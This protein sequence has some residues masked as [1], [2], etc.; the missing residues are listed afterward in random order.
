M[1]ATPPRTET[2][3][4]A[5]AR[6]RRQVAALATALGLASIVVSLVV[7]ALGLR[8]H[9]AEIDRSGQV[10]LALQL[11]AFK[12]VFD[13]YRPL[14]A[15]FSEH[16]TM[17]AFLREPDQPGNRAEL[18][19][20]LERL[21]G[22]TA[23]LDV[24]LVDQEHRLFSSRD[25]LTAAEI[26]QPDLQN[27]P[28]QGRLGRAYLARP[29]GL[30]PLAQ[31]PVYLFSHGIRDH[32]RY[33]GALVV[34]LG[35]SQLEQIWA[36]APYPVRTIDQEGARTLGNTL[37]LAHEAGLTSMRAYSSALPQ[38]GWTL[39][40]F[41]SPAPAQWT[42]LTSGLLAFA[43]C[44]LLSAA[45]LWIFARSQRATIQS[46][47]AR[48][49]AQRLDRL[50]R[51]RTQELSRSNSQLAREVE[52]RKQTEQELRTA[53]AGLVQTSKLAALGQMSAVLSHEF[54]Q[55]LAAISS[56]V[57]N[58]VVLLERDDVDAGLDNL[59]QVRDMVQRLAAISK[60][61]RNFARKPR[62]T[63]SIVPVSA[64]LGDALEIMSGRLKSEGV[65]LDFRP[66]EQ[67]LW[68]Q[69]GQIRLQQVIVNLISNAIQ[70]TREA[71]P[72][73][74]I[75][76]WVSFDEGHVDI[77]V[78]D[79]GTGLEPEVIPKVF[80]PFFTTKGVGEGLGLGL[81]ISYSIIDDFGGQLSAGN[82]AADSAWPGACFRVHLIRCAEG[83]LG[84]ATPSKSNESEP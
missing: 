14:P 4:A 51:Q 38:F 50:V 35:L 8:L 81:S 45:I 39:Q 58:A 83:P 21:T 32:G 67:A 17:I 57:D 1:A 53:Q 78:A 64:V 29:A 23:A 2:V 40:L 70:A 9:M 77:W 33:L 6:M 76:V 66:P 11:E 82:G 36:L 79:N 24:V 22:L 84:E 47:R 28:R 13:R 68:V 72:T 44:L 60:H 12:R 27:A 55:P 31:E 74:M 43:V 10:Q 26:A 15:L 7:S 42:G 73:P 54:N 75:Q 65:T 18:E 61:L 62:E 25:V 63:L 30:E 46:L 52:E 37:S 56:Y 59:E 80:D 3:Q 48:D 20:R 34:A 41:L 19:R 5:L 49:L 69:A 16:P 71:Q